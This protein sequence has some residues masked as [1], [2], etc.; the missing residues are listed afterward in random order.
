LKGALYL[1]DGLPIQYKVRNFTK[2][3]L[4]KIEDNWFNIK[5]GL[6]S[7]IRLVNKFGFNDKN[8]TAAMALLPI[9]YYLKR[10]GKNNYVNS[11][12][13]TD[14]ENQALIQKWLI[15][16]LLNNSFGGSSDTTLT[17]LRGE[18]S[19]LRDF[20]NFPFYELNRRLGIGTE[21]TDDEID[22]LLQ[23]NYKTRYSFLILSLL[24]PDRDW[25]DSFY[26]EDHIYPKSEF[27]TAKLRARGY[28]DN[29]ID[30]YQKYG[31]TILNLQLLTDSENLAKKAKDFDTRIAT[32]DENFKS[33]H[34]IPAMP[35]CH[36]DNFLDFIAERKNILKKALSLL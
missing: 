30:E 9:A 5:S 7:T 15:L 29:G 20:S 36:F 2:S 12:A 18:L 16:A 26:H 34:K 19:L 35:S 4:E 14:V 25:K 24:Y 8:I 6:E 28:N 11:T 23:N 3:N 32:R 31:N 22:N 21:F 33:R 13:Q 1:T 27:T 17:N 10:L